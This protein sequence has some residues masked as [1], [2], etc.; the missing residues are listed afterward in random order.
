MHRR[1]FLSSIGVSVT[2]PV[3]L[4]SKPVLS[5][6][7]TIGTVDSA[8]AGIESVLIN[9]KEFK[10]FSKY[11]DDSI[12]SDISVVMSL[13]GKVVETVSGTAM[14]MNNEYMCLTDEFGHISQDDLDLDDQLYSDGQILVRVSH[15]SLADDKVF[16]RSFSITKFSPVAHWRLNDSSVSGDGGVV[17]DVSGNG[18]D[19]ETVNGVTT[20]ADGYSG[21]AFEFD[22][23]SAYI[24]LPSLNGVHSNDG[25]RTVVAWV[26]ADSHSDTYN[27]VFQ[28]GKPTTNN[29]FSLATRDDAGLSEHTWG[30]TPSRNSVGSVPTNEWVHLAITY[31]KTSDTRKYYINGSLAGSIVDQGAPDTVFSNA[32]IGARLDTLK[33]Y[34]DGRIQDVRLYDKTLTEQQLNA[35]MSSI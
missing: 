33:E 27:H 9:F 2:A 16:R 6:D 31:N 11:I 20:D 34:W 28:Y 14:L 24:Q 5:A 32:R 26:Y 23:S 1:A 10:I 18:F 13:E 22:G 15:P 4:S 19:G 21:T 25:D 35:V 30:G 3:Y 12:E 7:I 29:A 17:R 8:S